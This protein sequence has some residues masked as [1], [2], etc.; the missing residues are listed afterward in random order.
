M[1]T[2]EYDARQHA[3]LL[4]DQTRLPHET[5]MVTCRT[6]EDVAHA[7]R[8]M[9]VRGAP[10]IGVAAAYGMV[11]GARALRR[12]PTPP[13]SS[14]TSNGVDALL[15]ADAADGGQ[16]A[17][18][19]RPHARARAAR[20]PNAT[21]SRPRRQALLT[22]ADAMAEEDVAANRSMGAFGLDLV[23]ERRERADPLQRRRAGHRRLRHRARRGPRRARGRHAASTSSSTRRGRSSRAR[24]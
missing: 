10:A 4:I 16:P 11:L 5:V 17:L 7:I 20:S 18:G 22:L 24:G 14:R 2:L 15:R 6:A 9:Q 21:A 19:A 8:S 1:R 23:P 13:A 12:R 3:L